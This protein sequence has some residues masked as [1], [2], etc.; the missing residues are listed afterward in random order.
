MKRHLALL[1]YAL[2]ALRRRQRRNIAIGVGLALV[3]GLYASVLFLTDSLRR[4]Y[5]LTIEATP[6][7]VLQRMIGGRPALL[8]SEDAEAIAER[9]GVA[10]VYPRVWGYHFVDALSGNLTII[11]AH[12]GRGFPSQ[13]VA[14]QPEPM[15]AEVPQVLVGSALAEALGLRPGDRLALPDHAGRTVILEATGVFEAEAALHAADVLVADEATARRLLGIP[16][17]QSTDIAIELT[18][19]DEAGVVAGALSETIAGAR[20]LDRR[21]LSRTYELTFDGRAGLLSVLFLPALAAFLLLAWE[22]LTGIGDRERREIGVLKAVGWSTTDVLWARLWE[23]LVV[24]VFGSWIGL[25]GAYGYVFVAQAPGLA[26]ALLGWSALYPAMDLVPAVD[27][28]QLFSLLG[29][30]I[31]PFVGIS[32]VPAW[33]A[34]MVDPDQAMRGAE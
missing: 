20:V 17:G 1:A 9:P 32:I 15:A 25:L 31:V 33:R 16:E 27:A 14:G 10:A 4:E 6:D 5:R 2:G 22:R 28:A 24:A 23:A 30:V 29:M 12:G 18:T 26:G 7:L 34:A 21:A 19:P 13:L 8:G 11:G 3:V